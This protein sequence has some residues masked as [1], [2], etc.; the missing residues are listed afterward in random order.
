MRIVY[1]EDESADAQL[2]ERYAN[3]MNHALVVTDSI[4][5]AK[6]AIKDA[7]DLILVDMSIHQSRI[8]YDFVRE[9]RTQGFTKPIVA[10]TGLT[11]APDVERC[12]EVGC[13]EVLTK[14]Y[15]INQLAEL[16]SRYEVQSNR[17]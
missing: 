17:A 14:P 5:K 13:D 6:A 4:Q 7:P 1:I 10:V 2:V 3:L 16:F 15:T 8:G 9:I 11:L 12:Y